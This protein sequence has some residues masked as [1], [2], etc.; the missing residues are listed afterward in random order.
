MTPGQLALDPHVRGDQWP[1]ISRVGP[2]TIDG[3]APA[4]AIASARMTFR[5]APTNLSYGYTLSTAQVVGQGTIEIL[6]AATWL[7]AINP[8]PLPLAE[9]SW[10]WDLE[11]TPVDQPPVT[12]LQGTLSVLPDQSR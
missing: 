11:I 1:G 12:Y 7:L 8:Q 2:I 3:V 10:V 5:R 9:G 4:A 6:N